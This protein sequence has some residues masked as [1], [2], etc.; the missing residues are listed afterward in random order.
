MLGRRALGV[1]VG[2]ELELGFL[3]EHGEPGGARLEPDVE[4][5]HLPA[6]VFAAAL[7]AGDVLR[8]KIS[9]VAAVPGV[10]TFFFEEL[11]DGLVD[12]GV[13]QG[14]VAFFT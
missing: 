13:V 6:E 3:L 1:H 8:E 10:G 14:L 4:D 11:D 2:R 5:V 12:G 7:G 9:D